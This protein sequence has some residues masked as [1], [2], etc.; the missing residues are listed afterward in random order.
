VW[1]SH[2]NVGNVCPRTDN[3]GV[4]DASLVFESVLLNALPMYDKAM[5]IMSSKRVHA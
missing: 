1:T 4:V 2:R 5:N 3:G